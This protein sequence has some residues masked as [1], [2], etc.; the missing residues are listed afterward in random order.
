MRGASRW[1]D[2]PPGSIWNVTNTATPSTN[3][4]LFFTASFLLHAEHAWNV[5]GPLGDVPRGLRLCIST[6]AGPV[7][8]CE[9]G[10]NTSED[11]L[12]SVVDGVD[13]IHFHPT[14]PRTARANLVLGCQAPHSHCKTEP[15][16]NFRLHLRSREIRPASCRV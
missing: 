3:N 1:L 9:A 14:P 7:W 15:P 12:R 16:V 4:E 10:T 5:R 2:A 6:E 13:D 11:Q 8:M